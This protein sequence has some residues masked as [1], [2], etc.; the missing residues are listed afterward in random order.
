M[1]AES[2]I[3]MIR[4]KVR[5]IKSFKVKDYRGKSLGVNMSW[6]NGLNDSP[7]VRLEA[8]WINL[9]NDEVPEL[10]I[11]NLI[12]VRAIFTWVV[13]TVDTALHEVFSGACWNLNQK[14]DY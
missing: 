4:V 8:K 7:A 2:S 6:F 14:E 9:F 12:G 10:T 3:R 5:V 11:F 1:E 13:D